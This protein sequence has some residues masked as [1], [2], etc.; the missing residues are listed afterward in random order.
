MW[1]R[2]F[3]SALLAVLAWLAAHDAT[4]AVGPK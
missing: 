1:I 2:F 3:A 4:G